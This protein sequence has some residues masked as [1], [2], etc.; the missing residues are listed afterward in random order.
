[1]SEKCD[2]CGVEDCLYQQIDRLTAELVD[3]KER[4]ECKTDAL[5]ASLMTIDAYE[6]EVERLKGELAEAMDYI[7]QLEMGHG[8]KE[9]E[10]Y[11]LHSR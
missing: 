7:H 2:C 8:N 6:K 4:Y 11:V 5:N 3:L 10:D 9:D 1:M